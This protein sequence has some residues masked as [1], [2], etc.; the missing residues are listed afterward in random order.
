MKTVSEGADVTSLL[1]N[2]SLIACHSVV[3][4]VCRG[5]PA[6]WGEPCFDKIEATLAHAMLSIPATKVRAQSITLPPTHT[7]CQG[8]EI[9]SGFGGARM[10]GSAHND[11]F[12][13]KADGQLGTATN[14]SG[15]VQG[16]AP[17]S[18]FCLYLGQSVMCVAFRFHALRLRTCVRGVC[19]CV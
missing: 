19:V 16:G 3:S 5:L 14:N 7:W 11:R 18:T 17:P 2:Q 13:R 4:C 8:F 1:Y 12:V 9:G 6:G 10:R 15:G